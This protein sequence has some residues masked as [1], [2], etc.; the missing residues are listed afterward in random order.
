MET[1]SEES[2]DIHETATLLKSA[3]AASSRAQDR[4]VAEAPVG[5]ATPAGANTPDR[6]DGWTEAVP[7]GEVVTWVKEPR[8][9][10]EIV[11]L[12]LWLPVTSILTSTMVA[13]HDYSNLYMCRHM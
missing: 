1:A 5:G 3:K 13:R 10:T 4:S 11:D 2:I 6:A 8:T 7:N 9:Q 12:M